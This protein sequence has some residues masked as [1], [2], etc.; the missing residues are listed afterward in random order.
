M[1]VIRSIA[2]FIGKFNEG[3]GRMVSWLATLLVIVV[4]ANVVM[5][6]SF[7]SSQ[8]WL[9]ELAWHVFATLFLLGAGFAL[10]HGK[11]VRVDL[12]Y[13]RLSE[14]GKSWIDLGGTLLFLIP[15]CLLV[16]NRSWDY[17][18]RAFPRVQAPEDLGIGAYISWFLENAERSDQPG[19]LPLRF[20]IKFMILLGFSFLLLQAISLFLEA[21]ASVIKPKE[22]QTTHIQRTRFRGLIVT[23]CMLIIS[24]MIIITFKLQGEG[25]AVLLFVELFVFILM[26]FPVAFTLGGAA[27]IFGFFFADTTIFF[28]FLPSRFYGIMSGEILMAVPLFIYMGIMLEKSGLA[29]RLLETMALLF[30]RF[31]GG[32]A[33][34]VVVV[35]GLL[36]ASTGIVGATVVTMGLISLP[37]MLKRGYSTEL[38]TGTIAS[39]GTLGQIIPP[40]IVLILLSSQLSASAGSSLATVGALFKAAVIPSILLVIGYIVYIAIMAIFKG[41]KAPAMPPEEVKEFREKGMGKRLVRALFLPLTLIVAV[42]GSIFTGKATPTEAAAVGA[43]GAS[44]LTAV[45]G[46]FS[47]K[48]VKEVAKETTHLTCMVFLILLGAT[49]FSLVFRDLGGDLYLVNLITSSNLPPWA[50]LLMVMLIIFIAGFFIDFIEIIF[51]I[52]PVVAPVFVEYDMNLVWIGILMALNL[53]TSFLSPPFGFS[54][55]YLK[56]VA[57]KS[58]TT[59]QIYRGII[60]FVLIQLAVL[61]LAIIFPELVLFWV[62]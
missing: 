50:F 16:I 11:H 39:S 28:N 30:G 49:A 37:T 12:V 27:V 10:K 61:A 17:V 29:E 13:S 31:R 19:G 52:V 20:L 43:L 34:A 41:D 7:D 44:I 6:Y 38:A 3:I 46:K 55:F 56:G 32:L 58:V 54:L 9:S 15:F 22:P 57:P 59:A 26:G 51:I 36:A 14:K 33:L 42:L 5:R 4:V 40:S 21:L 48:I 62:G 45:E 23:V 24:W 35:G 2:R 18:M 53:Q 47:L 8:Q 25:L 60:P 1:D